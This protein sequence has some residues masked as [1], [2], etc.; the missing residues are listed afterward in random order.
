M[1]GVKSILIV[2]MCL[3]CFT[4]L[5]QAQSTNVETANKI[6]SAMSKRMK[7]ASTPTKNFSTPTGRV[8]KSLE[9]MISLGSSFGIEENSGMMGKIAIGLGGVAEVELT[10]S[11]FINELTGQQSNLPTSIFKMGL[12]PERY[13]RYWY[14]PNVS[15][16]LHST[17]W[18]SSVNEGSHLSESAKETHDA[19]NLS[20]MDAN[21]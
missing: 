19:R 12:V 15:L 13:T 9:F 3:I 7:Y 21:R 8:L 18:K 10:Q 1:V 14:I 4:N 20:R 11:S 16:Q 17:P 2:L 5:L 6:K